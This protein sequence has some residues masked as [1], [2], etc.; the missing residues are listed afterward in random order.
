MERSTP[1]PALGEHT[2]SVL[3]DVLGLEPTRI[4]QLRRE[5][6]IGERSAELVLGGART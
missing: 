5:H 1:P 4:A 2:D 6:V 3:H